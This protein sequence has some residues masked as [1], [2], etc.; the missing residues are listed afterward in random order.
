MAS[1]EDE[2][3]KDEEAPAIKE[4]M[5]DMVARHKKELK[6]MQYQNRQRMKVPFLFA[7]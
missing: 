4:T 3:T 7:L 5:D 2:I 6:D 1:L